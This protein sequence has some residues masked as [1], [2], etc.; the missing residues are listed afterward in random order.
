MIDLDQLELHRRAPELRWAAARLAFEAFPQIAAR[1]LEI[2]SARLRAPRIP[3]LF[4][5]DLHEITPSLNDDLLDLFGRCERT[6]SNQFTFLAQGEDIPEEIDWALHHGTAW[7]AEMHAFDYG[8]E[9][10]L[11]YRM[12]GDTRYARHLR[13]LMAH[14]ISANPPGQGDGWSLTSLA[15]RVR[16]W[17]FASDLARRDW[18]NDAVFFSLIN[19]SLA[20][21]AQF[22]FG[23]ARS[24]GSTEARL[25]AAR[26]LILAGKF[27]GGNQGAELSA[28]GS[29][30]LSGELD[31]YFD[32][33]GRLTQSRPGSQLRL[34]QAIVEHL[35]FQT[36]K[37]VDEIDF[38][39]KLRK[40]LAVM[41]GALLPDGALP[42]F[43]ESPAPFGEELAD[44][45]ALSAVILSEPV[46]KSLAGK[47]GVVPYMIL[48]ETGLARF[49]GISQTSWTPT[50]CLQPQAGLYR[51]GGTNSSAMVINGRLPTHSGDHQDGFSYE[52]ALFGQRVVVD[53]GVHFP[54]KDSQEKYFATARAHNVLLVDGEGPRRIRP[55]DLPSLPEVWETDGGIKG[56]RLG[57]RGFFRLGI[58]HHRAWYCLEGQCWAVLDRLDGR[59]LHQVTS[60]L[61]FYPTFD[62]EV[63]ENAA[64]ARSRSLTVSVIPLGHPRPQIIASRGSGSRF[65]GWF[66]PAIGMKYATSVMR[67]E[68]ETASWPWIGGYLI[69]PGSEPGIEVGKSDHSSDA[70]SFCL[71]GKEYRLSIA[72]SAG[73]WRKII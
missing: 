17:V 25:D 42:L 13:Y 57:H 51:L 36:A 40:I 5:R 21:Q 1:T 8:L 37:T 10:A 31:R 22:L 2:T 19:R 12:S 65:E 48:G 35:V 55:D 34:A 15:R 45:F 18:E 47:F 46:W 72:G 69:V 4:S 9:L 28:A 32:V 53:S 63:G 66:S 27:F 23:F 41:A 59:G 39:D 68:W 54:E 20:L 33:N 64:I 67:L 49:I 73:A 14:W 56:L 24:L 60:L 61:H 29:K 11:N 62:L 71:G 58:I 52:L 38:K 6:L 70:V 43:G 3:N 26:A 16:N 7:G 50:T 30:I 44:L